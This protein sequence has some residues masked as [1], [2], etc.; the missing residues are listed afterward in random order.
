MTNDEK[1]HKIAHLMSNMISR[2]DGTNQDKW[3]DHY[4]DK[5]IDIWGKEESMDI[6]TKLRTDMSRNPIVTK[7]TVKVLEKLRS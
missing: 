3:I 4:A 2:I 6:V 1:R 5:F 7:F